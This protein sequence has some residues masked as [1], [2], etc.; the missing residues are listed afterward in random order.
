M[1]KRKAMKKK[2]HKVIAPA[3]ARA[4]AIGGIGW[5]ESILVILY[6]L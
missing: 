1:N 3:K 2:W 6:V 4:A 5:Y